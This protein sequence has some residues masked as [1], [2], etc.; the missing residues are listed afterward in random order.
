MQVKQT[1]QGPTKECLSLLTQQMREKN[2]ML[3]LPYNMQQQQIKKDVCHHICGG[4]YNK[5]R[6]SLLSLWKDPT[7]KKT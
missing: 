4:T 7:I 1:S 6:H 5:K 2:S 3:S